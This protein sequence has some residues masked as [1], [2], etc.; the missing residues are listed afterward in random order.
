MAEG[1]KKKQID[2]L[3]SHNRGDINNH[4]LPPKRVACD[5]K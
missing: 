5:H 3:D 2:A 4:V 1:E